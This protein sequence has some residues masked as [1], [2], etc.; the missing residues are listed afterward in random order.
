MDIEKIIINSAIIKKQ[1]AIDLSLFDLDHFCNSNHKKVAKKI[2][3]NIET[4]KDIDLV[5]LKIETQIP[6]WYWVEL[7]QA[8]ITTN[9]KKCLRILEKSSIKK[10]IEEVAKDISQ[11][12]KKDY[13]ISDLTERLNELANRLL[14]P[15][16]NEKQVKDFAEK[17]FEENFKNNVNITLGV[18]DFDN[19]VCLIDGSFVIIAADPGIG[20]SI[21]TMQLAQNNPEKS[22]IFSL[23]MTTKKI[24][25]R[26]LC[27]LAD[28]K[29]GRIIKGS[30]TQEENDRLKRADKILKKCNLDI[31]DTP[32]K[33]DEIVIESK[34][35]ALHRDIK[36]IVVDYIQLVNVSGK[37]NKVDSIEEVSRKLK[38]LANELNCCVVGISNLNREVSKEGRDPILSD[39]KGSSCLEYDADVVM[40]LKNLGDPVA[41]ETTIDFCIKKSRDFQPGSVPLKLCKKT[42]QYK[43]MPITH[44]MDANSF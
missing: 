23:E 24:Y 33:I 35:R 1:N 15:K 17:G 43:N 28:V 8:E 10:R 39:L 11:V 16:K 5:S 22:L 2:K 13:N 42:F 21:F 31:I 25:G 9:F 7:L 32:L 27:G 4:G 34:K 37:K 36:L 20:K 29:L 19:K 41:T 6:D 44:F 26:M 14:N 38:L 18:K 30:L 12:V 3:N 40:F